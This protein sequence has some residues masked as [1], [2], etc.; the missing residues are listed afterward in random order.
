MEIFYM[1]FHRCVD[2]FQSTH[3]YSRILQGILSRGVFQM[4]TITR[5][6]VENREENANSMYSKATNWLEH[7]FFTFIPRMV[8]RHPAYLSLQL[9]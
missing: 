8:Y 9:Q 3:E 2:L 7:N 1:W 5:L 4:Y 6:Y